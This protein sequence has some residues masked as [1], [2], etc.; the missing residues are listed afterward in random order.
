M[1]EAISKAARVKMAMRM[2]K[3]ASKIARKKAIAAKKMASSDT[4]KKRSEKAART[5]I[6]KKVTIGLD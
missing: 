4:L 6:M 2:K 1:D 3:L 5:L